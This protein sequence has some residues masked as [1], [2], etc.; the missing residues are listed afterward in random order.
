MPTHCG[1]DTC[2]SSVVAGDFIYLAHHAGGFDKPDIA[3]QVRA[4]FE[5]ALKTEK[6]AIKLSDDFIQSI[7]IT[8]GP[9]F[10]GDLLQRIEEKIPQIINNQ[11]TNESSFKHL[12]NYI[13]LCS[14][15]KYN[16]FQRKVR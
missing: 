7:T 10:S 14:I 3:H 1:D 5:N 15:Y 12:V 13:I 8:A 2:S 16:K 9:Y 6:I 4:A 11:Q